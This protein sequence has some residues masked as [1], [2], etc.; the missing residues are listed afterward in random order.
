MCSASSYYVYLRAA[1]GVVVGHLEQ[2]FDV[3]RLV[4]FGTV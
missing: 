1:E 2:G 3:A 4:L